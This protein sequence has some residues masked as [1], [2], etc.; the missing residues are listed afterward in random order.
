MIPEIGFAQPWWLLLLPLTALP[1]LR[2]AQKRL[3]YPALFLLPDASGARRWDRIRR[4]LLAACL[5][6]VI[7][8][9][10]GPFFKEQKI[11]RV[12]TGAH[13]TL[14]I[15]HSSSMNENFSGRYLGGGAKET[16]SAAARKLLLQFIQRRQQ[17]LFSVVAFSTAPRLVLPLTEDDTAIQAAIGALGVRGRG[18]TNIGPGLA[19]ALATFRGRPQTGARVI[20][21]V[22]DGAARLDQDVQ[23]RLRQDFQ[24][25]AVN[26]YWIYLRTPNS[27][28]VLHPPERRLSETSTPEVFLH[29]YFQTLKVPY[30]VFEAENPASLAEAIAAI[31]RLEN[32]PLHYF[33]TLPR[34]NL[35]PYT[36]GIALALGLPLLFWSA[37]EVNRWLP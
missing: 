13:I 24:D 14:T 31:G 25:L 15:D 36:F 34:R 28:S 4:L 7:V 12:G 16:K 23:D 30:R 6:A 2:P 37:L 8:S 32:Q 18:I 35:A 1:F 22:S 17:D 20:L 26:L 19:M 29:R 10:T 3:S 27:V 11:A 9:L 21:L 5:G 33:Q